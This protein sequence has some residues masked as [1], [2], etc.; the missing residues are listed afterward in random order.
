MNTQPH[1]V[2]RKSIF[3]ANR[4]DKFLLTVLVL[5]FFAS[6]FVLQLGMNMRRG[7]N[8]DEHQFVAGAALIVREHQLPYIDFPYFHVP[9]L[10]LFYGIG[11]TLTP[12]L[13]LG[14]RL[15]SVV[16]AWLSLWLLFAA[17]FR[18]RTA[19]QLRLRLVFAMLGALW[20]ASLPLFTYTSGRAWNHDL[21]IF[22]LLLAFFVHSDTVVA[23]R[24]PYWLGASGLL[25]GLAA[26]TRLS[27]ALMAIPFVL[28]LWLYP[29]MRGR[30]R[31]WGLLAFLLGAALGSMPA[32][33]LFVRD[34][35]AFWFN[36]IEYIGLNTAYYRAAGATQAM[37]FVT[38]L[39]YFGRLL[40]TAPGNLLALVAFLIGLF[41]LLGPLR[42]RLPFVRQTYIS[43]DKNESLFRLAFVLLILLFALG[44]A[45]AATPSQ[46]Q[47]FY[48]L[49]PLLILGTIYAVNAWPP[50]L[51]R[52]GIQLFILGAAISIGLAVPAYAPGLA[53]IFRPAEWYP[54]KVHARGQI[55]ANLVDQKT[56]L[57]LA[58]IHALEGQATIY[59]EFATGPFA[60]RVAPLVD[61]ATRTRYGLIGPDDLDALLAEQPPAGI[62]VGLE[63]DDMQ[64]EEPLIA[65]AQ[66]HA[67]V[68]IK[69]PDE[70]ILYT[71]PQA[72]WADTIQLGGH[73]LPA[74]PWQA[75]DTIV[76]TLYLQ[77][78]VT[79]EPNLNVLVRL[80]GADGQELLRDE[81]WPWGSPTS[82]WAVNDVWPDG[83]ELT[84][85]A[86][87]A[88]GFYALEVSFY[89][90]ANFDPLGEPAIIDYL[91]VADP[92]TDVPGPAQARW[93]DA[94]DLLEVGL[95]G[96]P[97][98]GAILPVE[99]TWQ[100]QRSLEI[101]Y[102]IF[103]HL[104]DA[105]GAVVAQS[106]SPPL[107]G[108]LP[109]TVWPPR[110]PV[111]DR[112][113][114]MLPAGLAPGTYRIVAG[115]YD[116]LDGTRL[117]VAQNDAPA[118]DALT[119]ATFEIQ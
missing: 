24:S 26:T 51:H 70:G 11:Y 78:R 10:S 98:P 1:S 105:N 50:P 53:V 111:A 113:E 42:R 9:L 104:L 59:P 87:T 116:P 74:G 92:Q 39:G 45:F 96:E 86:D 112:S 35:A 117:S 109:T 58:P 90:P 22:L 79:L 21:P 101:D 93:G 97:A 54:L 119:V 55:V 33:V 103:I 47:Y 20:L 15:A 60:W 40:V 6:L 29:T 49:F 66:R 83:H 2:Q 71:R 16:F 115:L 85:P 88:P 41:P 13:L 12:Y 76:L 56:V 28:V 118:G 3:L 84:L 17:A 46:P 114:L 107:R 77:N 110:Q 80:I 89:D 7:L 38:K 95:A 94:I 34:P 18:Q 82:T 62:L 27:F 75:G 100:T 36:N 106:D 99:L 37:T 61:V 4:R 69:L 8:H 73:V 57:T 68:P 32:L 30:T 5:L 91:V 52:R 48:P 67:Y 72:V 25:M 23:R 81:G 108:F 31:Q 102:T 63:N 19:G 14:A 64:E 65:Y 44:G 43:G